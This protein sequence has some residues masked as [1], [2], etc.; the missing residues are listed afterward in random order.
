MSDAE[1]RAETIVGLAGTISEQGFSDAIELAQKYAIDEWLLHMASLEFLLD[2]T[3]NVPLSDVKQIM[4][5]R[6]H[7]SK[8]RTKLEDFH[9]RLRT[10]VLPSLETNEQFIAYTSL[11]ADSEP[12]KKVAPTIKKILEKKKSVEAIRIWT[13]ARYLST[14][15]F[16]LPDGALRLVTNSILSIPKIGPE[17]CET[18]AEHLLDG[19]EHRPPADPY[20]IFLLMKSNVEDFIDLIANKKTVSV[21]N[22]IL[23]KN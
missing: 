1:Y 6:G 10:M 4:K 9:A 23:L 15:L 13:D 2:P 17:G 16:E 18:A 20:T 3:Y 12:E 21:G 7:L 5:T 19:N 14:V 22:R 11:F 8:L